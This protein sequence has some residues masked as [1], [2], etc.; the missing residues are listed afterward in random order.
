LHEEEKGIL[1]KCVRKSSSKNSDIYDKFL[2]YYCSMLGEKIKTKTQK[3]CQ[4]VFT[5][6]CSIASI[7]IFVSQSGAN[8]EATPVI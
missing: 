1:S 2:Q 5:E 6:I 3:H 7:K 8:E 4:Q